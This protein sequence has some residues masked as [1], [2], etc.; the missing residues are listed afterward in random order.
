MPYFLAKTAVFLIVYGARCDAGILGDPAKVALKD[1]E[2]HRRLS[3]ATHN[4]LL[5]LLLDT[6]QQMMLEVRTL[7]STEQKLFDRVM[8]MHRWIIESVAARNA[9][10]A[11]KAM[12]EH[13]EIALEI[14]REL[15][16]RQK[17]ADHR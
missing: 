5:V 2:F 6:I 9:A 7:V 16:E 10:G 1:S 12:R 17:S 13:V 15:I 8:P 11:R 4:P 3:E 14:Q